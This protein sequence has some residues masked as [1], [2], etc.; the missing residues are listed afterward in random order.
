VN[1]AYYLAISKGDCYM[2]SGFFANTDQQKKKNRRKSLA[3]AIMEDPVL[4]SQL[5]LQAPEPQQISGDRVEVEP[6]KDRKCTIL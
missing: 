2:R 5:G 4:A 1:L 6:R 3:V